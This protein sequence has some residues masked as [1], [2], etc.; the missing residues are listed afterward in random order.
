MAATPDTLR[1]VQSSDPR[2]DAQSQRHHQ[3]FRQALKAEKFDVALC[4]GVKLRS[5]KR[6]KL[7]AIREWLHYLNIYLRNLRPDQILL[8]GWLAGESTDYADT[9]QRSIML[10]RPDFI[11]VLIQTCLSLHPK[12][13][14]HLV[15]L[16]LELTQDGYSWKD[17]VSFVLTMAVKDNK[18]F[19]SAAKY[20]STCEKLSSMRKMFMLNSTHTGDNPFFDGVAEDLTNDGVYLRKREEEALFPAGDPYIRLTDLDC[21]III[22]QVS[23]AICLADKKRGLQLLPGT[24]ASVAHGLYRRAMDL[25][26][27]RSALLLVRYCGIG[28]TTTVFTEFAKWVILVTTLVKEHWEKFAVESGFFLDRLDLLE[29]EKVYQKGHET[30]EAYVERC[31]GFIESALVDLYLEQGTLEDLKAIFE[32]Y[33]NAGMVPF[34]L[35]DQQI[36][37]PR[38]FSEML[39]YLLAQKGQTNLLCR[40]MVD[41]ACAATGGNSIATSGAVSLVPRDKLEVPYIHVQ[42]HDALERY[43]IGGGTE[44]KEMW[45]TLQ[46]ILK[47]EDSEVFNYAQKSRLAI[48]YSSAMSDEEMEAG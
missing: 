22:A 26:L 16:F 17:M 29:E 6:M 28:I 11:P 7:K 46:A 21:E 23:E 2:D 31:V 1:R 47:H 40:Y 14:R 38:N 45:N 20:R 33:I 43:F 19:H 15:S 9:V 42:L 18:A 39:W 10:L 36:V 24:D 37:D 27:F 4:T 41:W 32:C 13:D 48:S 3:I 25:K 30:P 12:D 34:L 35:L 8:S 44:A 5:N